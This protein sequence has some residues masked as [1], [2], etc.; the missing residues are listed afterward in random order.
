MSTITDLL[1]LTPLVPEGPDPIDAVNAW[2]VEHAAGQSFG[3]LSTD[4]AGGHKVF[5]N[6]VFA[7]AGNYFPLTEFL[8]AFASNAFGWSAYDAAG[9]I[10]IVDHE[11]ADEVRAVRPDGERMHGKWGE[12]AGWHR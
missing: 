2:C 11:H 10:C 9:T 7:C 6:R 12:L 8:E 1:I 3:E 4:G 5:T